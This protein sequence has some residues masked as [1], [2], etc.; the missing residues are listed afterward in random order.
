MALNK[1]EITSTLLTQIKDGR[2]LRYY[3][4]IGCVR[5]DDNPRESISIESFL[6]INQRHDIIVGEKKKD[7]EY[8]RSEY[9][10]YSTILNNLEVINGI[11]K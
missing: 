2:K 5:W 10:V 6:E 8:L 4:L 3:Y 9:Q 1:K 11:K 7:S